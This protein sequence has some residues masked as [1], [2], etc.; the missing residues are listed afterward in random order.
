MEQS[1]KFKPGQSGN[2]NGR[3]KGAADRRTFFTEMVEPHKDKLF[4]KALAMALKGDRHILKLFLEHFLP[5]KPKDDVVEIQL[6][7][8]TLTEKSKQVIEALNNQNITP[9]EAI[10]IMQA[11]TAQVRI[12]ESDEI[13]KILAELKANIKNLKQK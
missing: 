6:A 11:L 10:D 8:E 1:N 13:T 3:P 12:Y 7:G 2:L 5:A 4:A 9:S